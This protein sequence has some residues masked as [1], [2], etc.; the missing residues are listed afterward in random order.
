MA[1]PETEGITDIN[2]YLQH[3]NPVV[4]SKTEVIDAPPAATVSLG[5]KAEVLD[6]PGVSA[7][8]S[9]TGQYFVDQTT[10]CYILI[11]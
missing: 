5:S 7:D 11:L 1:D 3:L 9:G 6:T 2:N 4:I 10:G 8:A